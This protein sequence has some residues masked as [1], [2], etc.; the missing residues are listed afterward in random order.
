VSRALPVADEASE[1]RNCIRDLVALSTMPGMWI[2]REPQRIA[3][4]IAD[5]LRTMLRA[6]IALV[7]LRS[8]HGDAPLEA[9]ASAADAD[10]AAFSAAI[11]ETGSAG[12]H[13]QHMVVTHG[14]T[15]LPAVLVPVG[16][17]GERG[18]FAVG[19]LRSDF[20]VELEAVLVRVAAA[21]AAVALQ[22]AELLAE[23]QRA[24]QNA[25]DAQA[26]A[27][28]ANRSKSEFLAMMSHELR[29]PLNAIAGYVE[30]LDM[31]L[32]GPVTELQRGDLQRVR[33]SQQYLLGLINDVLNFTKLES[34]SVKINRADVVVRQLFESID[35]LIRPQ[36]ESKRLQYETRLGNPDLVVYTDPEK[37]HQ[38]ILNL[39]SNAVKF[40]EAGGCVSLECDAG[41]DWVSI[42]V[43][44]SGSGI[45]PDK[46]DAIFEPF[47][48]VHRKLTN[49]VEGTGLGLAI[50]RDLAV[51]LGGDLSV[52][53]ELGKGSCFVI[54]L[55]CGN[56]SSSD[57]S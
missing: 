56:V 53:S 1:L 51:A 3:D 36:M 31:G 20:P 10:R 44:D 40:T 9:I 22:G 25:R 28:Q 57:E 42:R 19:A 15:T 41:T 7:R 27:E 38:I 35:T 14:S 12:R 30:L 8:P 17:H 33:H 46:T 54:R 50:S 5:L 34:G 37:L 4:D 26:E 39:L 47:V 32:R 49:T 6:H 48:Q 45:P 52:T 13:I 2:G 11:A 29:T 55:P 23:R 21:Q 16:L 24:L 18:Y 43:R